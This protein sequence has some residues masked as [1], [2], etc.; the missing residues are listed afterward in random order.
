MPMASRAAPRTF[1]ASPL[2][3]LLRTNCHCPKPS[4]ARSQYFCPLR[5]LPP[6]YHTHTHTQLPLP[7]STPQLLLP[8][9]PPLLPTP[10]LST[11][12]RHPFSPPVLSTRSLHPFSP[13]V[14][15]YLA[16]PPAPPPFP[17]LSPPHLL[18]TFSAYPRSTSGASGDA[19][20]SGGDPQPLSQECHAS[21]RSRCCSGCSGSGSGTDA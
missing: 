20:R 4:G 10:S 14:P 16:P 2:Q 17:S 11:P 3:S 6:S 12:S 18:S 7:F 1:S 13:P 8:F 21:A 9:S 15:A 5:S 19:R